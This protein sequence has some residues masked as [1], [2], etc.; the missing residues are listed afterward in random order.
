[1][2]SDDALRYPIG[3]FAAQETY[4]PAEIK[5]NIGRIESLPAKIEEIAKSLS[6]RQLETPY[7]QEGWTARQV[8]HHISDSHLN[9]YIR[10]KWTLTEETPL[11][12]AYEEKD[13]ALTPETK[14]DPAISITL[15]K[16]LH[17]KWT[18]LLY[19]LSADELQ[20]AFVHPETKKE[21]K[22]ERQI[23][24]YA[25]HGEHHLGHLKIVASKK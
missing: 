14:F 12:K 5:L 3:K 9:A 19:T 2:N 10:T 23:A 25:W 8:L 13:W 1:M 7:R 6:A 4:T 20:R 21:V 24:L 17:A 22:L 18:A 16:A 11:I 15:L